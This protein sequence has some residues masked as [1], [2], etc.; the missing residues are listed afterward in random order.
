MSR[1]KFIR[2]NPNESFICQYC[3]KAVMPLLHGGNQRNHCPYCLSS[4]H[5]D[6]I[7][8]DRRAS[9][10]NIMK[11]ISIW[12]QKNREWSVIHRCNGCGI[13]RT[14]RIAADDNEML[15][16]TLAASF[17]S[18]LPFPAAKM[19]NNLQNLSQH[20]TS[21]GGGFVWNQK[22]EESNE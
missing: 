7:P 19:I 11:P 16:F 22:K 1:K 21:K 20:T 4:I 15:L 8:G 12:I 3:K 5:V 13:I 2:E 6:I 9:C 14:N 18:Q 17:M 10:R